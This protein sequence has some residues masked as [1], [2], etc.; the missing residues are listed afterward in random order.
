MESALSSNSTIADP[1]SENE[2]AE[3]IIAVASEVLP[4]I[5]VPTDSLIGISVRGAHHIIILLPHLPSEARII[6]L[7]GYI[8]SAVSPSNIRMKI[9]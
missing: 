7:F 3:A 6:Y 9:L 5:V 4:L 8:T 1:P 2:V